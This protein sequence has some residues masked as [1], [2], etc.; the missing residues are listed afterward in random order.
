MSITMLT[1]FMLTFAIGVDLWDEKSC[2]KN[3]VKKITIRHLFPVIHLGIPVKVVR[4]LIWVVVK[5]RRR[6]NVFGGVLG[7]RGL[8]TKQGTVTNE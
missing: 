3:S 2:M 4:R 1:T 6:A 7:E 8:E 5:G